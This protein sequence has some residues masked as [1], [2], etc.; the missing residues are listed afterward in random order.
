[1]QRPLA[2]HLV[3]DRLAR[4]PRLLAIDVEADARLRVLEL[5]RRQV[6]HVGPHQQRLSTGDDAETAMARRVAG[7]MDRRDPRKNLAAAMLAHPA[8]I[9]RH[10]LAGAL[11]IRLGLLRRLG[12]RRVGQP[13]R[14]LVGVHHDLGVRVARRTVLHEPA[15]MVGVQVGDE[16]RA[17]LLRLD[18]GERERR[19]GPAEG[20]RRC[21][22]AVARVDQGRLEAGTR[23]QEGVQ[24][25][26]GLLGAEAR[27]LEPPGLLLGDARDEIEAGLKP[28]VVERGDREVAEVPT[29][30]AR[31]RL[32][33]CHGLLRQRFRS[34]SIRRDGA[35]AGGS[36]CAGSRS[37]RGSRSP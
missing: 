29:Q 26:L 32:R 30:H 34:V 20:R 12:Q 37:R 10:R 22:V 21:E 18:A 4:R 1:M 25:D 28:A 13:M 8:G 31:K 16:H 19:P 24:R 2:C 23:D 15:D 7:Q 5:D 27:N 17:D 3:Q 6:H 36:R 33:S 35:C 9:G 11:E 14:R